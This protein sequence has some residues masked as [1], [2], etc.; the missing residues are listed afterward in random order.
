MADNGQFICFNGKMIPA[1]SPSLFHNNRGFCYGDALFET[2]H[3]NGTRIQ[4]F[5]EHYRRITT[6]LS[7]LKIKPP[8][9]F[10]PQNLEEA[11]TKLLNKNR[12]LKGARLRLSVFR[13]SGGYY[14]PQTNESS[15]LITATPLEEDLYTLNKKGLKI[16]IFRDI[17]KPLNRFSNMKTANSLLYIMAGIKKSENGVDDMILVNEKGNLCEG[18]AS[19]LFLVKGKEI[20]TPP[21]GDGCVEGV[22]RGQLIRIA[23]ENGFFCREKSLVENDLKEADEIFL[24]NAV[25]GITWVVAWKQKRYY[26]K[27]SV[28]LTEA[29]NKEQFPDT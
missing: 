2:I 16:D 7:L 26:K 28:M 11:M 1:T 4:F 13:N 5:T 18:I 8:R 9:F 10:G 12:I 6:H 29:L 17:H 24:S 3:A 15:Y 20:F 14:T 19:N 25:K 22:M 27:I 21:L 23:A